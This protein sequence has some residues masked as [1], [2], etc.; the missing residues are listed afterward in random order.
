MLQENYTQQFE[1]NILNKANDEYDTI[2]PAFTHLQVAQPTTFGHYLLCYFEM[3]LRDIKRLKNCR[4][5]LNECPLGACALCGTP[6]NTDRFFTAKKLEFVCPTRNSMDSVSDRD[7]AIE[8]LS[9]IS[10][11]AMHLSR[12]GEEFIIW[13]SQQFNYIKLPEE[14]TSGSSIMPQKKNPDSCELLRGK[15]GKIYGNLFSLLTTMKGLPLAY[16]KDMQE[17]KEVV[18]NSIDNIVL[19]IKVANEIIKSVIANRDI[20]RKSL[21]KGYPNAT[22]LADYLVKKINIPFR[23]AHRITGEIVKIAEKKNVELEKLELKDMQKI[24][25]KINNDVFDYININTSLNSRKSYG[26]TAIENVKQMI[27]ECN[28]II[29]EI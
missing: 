15:A 8:F 29:S 26:G 25:D 10:I 6:F 7:F 12:L 22:D 24:C 23:E 19:C 1:K 3:F 14:Y 9:C 21:L 11:I 17:D 18:F 27:I 20:M 13:S 5:I 16:Q 4:N 28:G 2:M